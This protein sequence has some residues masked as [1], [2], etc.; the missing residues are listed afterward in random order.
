MRVGILDKVL[1]E[2]T[3]AKK[4]NIKKK[5]TTKLVSKPKTSM[6]ELKDS[7]DGGQNA[8][9]GYSYQFLYSCYLMLS[10][11]KENV[12]FNLEGVED[13]DYI[14][15]KDGQFITHIQLK[16]STVK[17]DASFMPSVLKN[18]LEAYL[19]DKN[20]NFKLVYDFSVATGHLKKLFEGKLD[21]NSQKHWEAVIEEIKK[22]NSNWNWKEYNFE[23]FILK[24]SYENVK[25]STL[26]DEVEKALINNYGI[27]TGNIKLY[28]NSVKIFCFDKM[29]SRGEI[30][31]DD[32]KKRIEEVRFDISM[33]PQN[34]AHSWIKKIEFI[35]SLNSES[36]Y[37][38][39]K[40]ATP[41]DIAN[42]IP[43][44]RPII[45]KEL[46]DSVNK[47]M[48]TIIKSSSGQGKTTLALKT[49]Y[50]LK[51]EY[52]PYQ[53]ICC[54][55]RK[56]LGHIVEYFHSRIRL[57]EK[58]L[59]LL[60]NLD[61]HLSEWNQL[62]QLMQSE[63]TY[64]YK[65]LVTS[66][67]NDWY[68]YGGD[69]SNIHSMN[70]IKPVLSKEEAIEIFNIL[71]KSGHIHSKITDW[72]NP[73]EKIADKKL[74]IEYVYLLTHGEM[75]AERISAQMSEI[76]TTA[77]SGIKFEVLRTVCF[78]DMCGT[79]LSTRKLLQD[80]SG[81]SSCDV[82]EIL[83]SMA[84]EFL[85]HVSKDGDY[86]EGLHPVRSQHIVN[87]LHEYYPLEETVYNVTR[88]AD[89]K[90]FAVLFS[91][92]PEFEFDKEKF[93]SDIVQQWLDLEDLKCFVFAIR[94]TFSGSVMQYFKQNKE[95][96]NDANN[97]NGL[98]VLATDICPFA[99]FQEIDESIQ[100][101]E[102]IKKIMPDN[103]NIQ[104]L[105]NLRNTI[106][107]I[108]MNRTDIYILCTKLYNKLKAINTEDVAD[109]DS[110]AL[111]SDWL[112]NLDISLNLAANINLEN[113]WIRAEKCSIDT[114]SLLMYTSYC[115]NREIYKRFITENLE[116]ILTYLKQKTFSHRIFVTENT[117]HVEYVLRSSEIKKGNEESVSRLKY[118][119]RTLPVYEKYYSDAI[120]PRLDILEGYMIPDDAHKAMPRRNLVIMF[121]QE[122]ASL[123]MKTIQ[124]NYEFD[125]VSEWIEHWFNIRQCICESLDE[126]CICIYKLLEGKKIGSA[127]A[128]FD[129]K[130][131]KFESMICG[132]LS[133]P[134][135][136]RPFEKEIDVP[137]KFAKIRQQYF[138][139]IQNFLRQV[140]GLIK[141]N[142]KDSRLALFNLKLA[143]ASLSRMHE[144]FENMA[145]EDEYF[146]RH[147]GLCEYESPKIIETEMCCRYY[148][149]HNAN[150][151]FD[152]YQV[153]SW[154]GAV[155][156]KEISEVDVLFESIQHEY[157]I[158]F[159]IRA[160]EDGVL[161][162]YPII[163]KAFDWTNEEMVQ[164]FI[165]NTVAF[166]Q[167][168]FDYL[169]V[170]TSNE[171]NYILPNALKFSKQ[172]FEKVQESFV[173]GE[174]NLENAHMMPFPIEVTTDIMK[175]FDNDM[176]LLPQK[177]NLYIHNIGDM[178]EELW[179]YSKI[180][181][182]L[183]DE[184]DN[185]YCFAELKKVKDKIAIMQ[186]E[187]NDYLDTEIANQMNEL[188]TA[189]YSGDVFDDSQFNT[190]IQ[191]MQ[192]M[193]C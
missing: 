98:N 28:A 189:V 23:E 149:Q 83:K 40:K 183:S 72:K 131:E 153:K 99:Q 173:S 108:D 101:L 78:A 177:N 96:F 135:E 63:V 171:E 58:P 154:Y 192:V 92:Y 118:I 38:E 102:E 26:E 168:A 39:G 73:W 145:L 185:N 16:Y 91:H 147:L 18:F 167:S 182:L 148:L 7:R 93:Y 184:N 163:F 125:S 140:V 190:F 34:P 70:I 45:E 27:T 62:V 94:G 106:T 46:T 41:L 159:P 48:V 9:R 14:R 19:I 66:R 17:Q 178:A 180:R 15:E 110:Y 95:V 172:Y 82:G 85:V 68:N 89:I 24:I 191:K 64:N 71:K 32:I 69:I 56:E 174:Q 79:K 1:G 50:I 30:S 112:Y 76:G 127:G 60:D 162:S 132:V 2:L 120:M 130:R 139:N 141:R 100:I 128:E 80:L 37:Y 49:Q 97:H 119:C 158:V 104:Y 61:A 25:K 179:V 164:K 123:W 155:C 3:M 121:H 117:I 44:S 52:T 88:L 65:F 157:D 193:Y 133:Y 42:G 47:H 59:I 35:T 10:E 67:E 138:K 137:Q 12:I 143:T 8:L 170:L 31:L 6:E 116:R 4:K 54:N 122:F 146:T 156:K 87:R 105:L 20:R 136:H 165:V 81:K 114:V 111:I 186:K 57:G 151:Y 33:G 29:E 124:S 107:R 22:E 75:I 166:A 51:D 115:G 129:K 21:S 103:Q 43:V 36:D 53:I 77:E 152:K 90:D 86:V 113:L 134:K 144:F 160:Y 55:D 126:L 176:E 11:K 187:V 188:C 150:P 84:D 5:C 13:I 142:E 74:L 109:V 181:E 169:I 175:C 161:R